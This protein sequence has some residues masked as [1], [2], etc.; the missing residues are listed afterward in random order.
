[1]R[2]SRTLEKLSAGRTVRICGLSHFIPS[3]VRHA[4][5]FGFDCIWLDLEHR[6]MGDR[7][8]QALL[9]M[10][11]QHG[12]DIMVR[13]PTR[14]KVR[15]YRY[16]EDGASGL[17]I[18]HVTTAEEAHDLVQSTKF[19]PLGNRGI[20][21]AGLDSDFILQGGEGYTE[22]ANSETFLA[23]QIESPEAVSNVNEIAAVNGVTALFIG[24]ADLALRQRHDADGMNM[25]EATDKVAAAAAKHG[26][27][28][29]RPTSSEGLKALHE[30]GARLLAC[31]GEFLA[32]MQMLEETARLF[33][34]QLGD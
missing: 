8:V 29:G 9:A 21:A 33:D 6:A 23:V 3:F 32:I 22:A 30:K 31:G 27:F 24:P 34:E 17:M 10:S 28:W 14:E 2:A 1:M 25:E 15:L 5:H 20:D 16:L 7:E 13:S 11:H 19:P 12:I 18:P 4:S 26:K